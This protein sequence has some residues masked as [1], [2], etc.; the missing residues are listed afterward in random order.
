MSVKLGILRFSW[1]YYLHYCSTQCIVILRILLIILLAS[2]IFKHI[3]C[4]HGVY[5]PSVTLSHQISTRFPIFSPVY[6]AEKNS[7]Q[8][9]S[10]ISQFSRNYT[11]NQI[12]VT[13]SISYHL[14]LSNQ[15]KSIL[16]DCFCCCCLVLLLCIWSLFSSFLHIGIHTHAG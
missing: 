7:F 4:P 16:Q 15:T 8:F 2:I 9:L 3:P 13:F 6:H 1:P 12:M 11:A 14:V 10:L 5:L